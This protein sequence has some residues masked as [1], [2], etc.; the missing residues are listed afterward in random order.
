MVRFLFERADHFMFEVIVIEK[1]T[2]Q[3]V[4]D[5]IEAA[6]GG[7]PDLG[8][9]GAPGCIDPDHHEGLFKVGD[10]RMPAPAF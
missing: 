6:V 1:D 7:V 8:I 10:A 2:L 9:V 3:I 4:D 5:H